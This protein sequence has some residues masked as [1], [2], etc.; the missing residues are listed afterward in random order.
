MTAE[1][2]KLRG[3][4]ESTK[5]KL[6]ASQAKYHQ[7]L[8]AHQRSLDQARSSRKAAAATEAAVHSQGKILELHEEQ[9]MSKVEKAVADAKAMAKVRCL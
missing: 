7:L 5:K 4:L 3:E 1:N 6:S 2:S 8:E 9:T